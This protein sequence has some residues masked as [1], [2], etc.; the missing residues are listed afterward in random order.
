M[1]ISLIVAVDANNGIGYKNQL[2][3]H[4]PNDLKYFKRVTSGS[5]VLMGRKTFDSIGR[6]L[7]N[8]LNLVVSKS[9]QQIEGCEVF[10]S[11]EAAITFAQAQNQANFFIIGG[12]SIYKQALPLCNK[13][14][15]TRIHHSFDADAFFGPVPQQEWKLIASEEQAADEKNAYTHSF[16]VYE[17]I[18][19]AP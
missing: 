8:R 10:E 16:D 5:A 17:R 2:L 6:P 4:L 19:F 14:Y 18:I 7:P 15:L 13:L 11:I 12:D 1:E 3:C 9:V